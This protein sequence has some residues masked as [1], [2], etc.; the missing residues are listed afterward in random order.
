MNVLVAAILLIGPPRAA[1]S[2]DHPHVHH[3]ARPCRRQRDV[4]ATRPFAARLT[5]C[6]FA[7]A[8]CSSMR[9]VELPPIFRIR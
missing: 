5:S 4:T 3:T 9:R 2:A 6:Q 1:K 7:S 8:G